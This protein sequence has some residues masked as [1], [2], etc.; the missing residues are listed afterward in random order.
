MQGV[1]L[2][3]QNR[4][5]FLAGTVMH[6]SEEGP[7]PAITVPAALHSNGAPVSQQKSRN[8]DSIRVPV[9]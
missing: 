5:E 1:V 4:G 6:G 3:S 2:G 8:I 9:L 7:L